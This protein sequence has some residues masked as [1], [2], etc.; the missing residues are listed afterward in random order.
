MFIQVQLLKGYSEPLLYEIPSEWE[1]QNLVGRLVR[2]PIRTQIKS[3][4]VLEQFATKPAKDT[5]A[6]R[7]A[8]AIE[9]F[10]DDPRY[11]S[12]IDQLSIYYQVNPLHFIKRVRLFLA[13]KESTDEIVT[14]L[15]DPE[16]NSKTIQ[17]TDEQ[18]AVVNAIAPHIATPQYFPSVLHGVTGSGKT[19]I[20]KQLIKDAFA[21]RKN[22][23]LLLPEVTL[24]L[25]FEKLLRKELPSNIPI[26]SFHSATSIKDKRLLWQL[27]LQQTPCLVIGVHLPTLLPLP[28]LGLIVVDEEHEVGY[29]EKKHPKVNSKDAAIWRASL[30]KIPIIL[31]SATPSLSSLYNVKTKGWHFFQ[32]KKRF[33]GSFPTITTVFLTDKKP[34][35]TFWI[36][37]QLENAIH[38]RLIKKEQT[39]I[40]LNRRGFSFFVQCKACSFIFKCRN[41]SVSLTLHNDNTV[42]CHY[43]ALTMPLP[44]CCPTCKR[45]ESQF[46]KKGIGTQQ[47]VSLLAQLFPQARI[48]RADLDVTLKK[49][50]WQ[51]TLHD[52]EQGAIDILVGTQT[53]T[54]GFH[55]PN[56]T[57]VG[58]L[59][60]DLNL[61]FPLFNASET[62]LQQL[63]QV[64]GR[65]GRT[66]AYSD[67]IVQAM[68]DH[69][70]FAYLNELAYVNF[71]A[72][73]MS[74][75]QELGYPPYKRL[76]E[77]ELKHI[78]ESIVEREAS[79]LMNHLMRLQEQRNLDLQILG[80]AKPPVY[81]IKNT[82]IRKIYIK[83]ES[84]RAIAQIFSLID[85]SFFKSNIFFTPNPLG[86]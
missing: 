14:Q 69:P 10:P 45:N 57:L 4:L 31:G 18:Q 16:D 27:L 74:N 35:R 53:I 30:H 8:L 78:H 48:A 20:Y 81:K 65:A 47:V 7:Q 59:W 72:N 75:R 68:I 17:L 13:E 42:T 70:I 50:V 11:R 83:G 1:T 23:L 38:D 26:K 55:F 82:H 39:I 77:L 36:S 52:F 54:K 63:I 56:V 2:V 67:V 79:I 29:Q 24:A 76:V 60:A 41:C 62:T 22:S 37:K 73:E 64:A 21:A 9:S 58:I 28:N 61:H 44:S 19:E 6:V 34:R 86:A 43:C 5:F 32:L 33:A 51:Q 84:I 85:R 49:K 80:P 40:F 46:L 12:F 15:L 3:A 66:H 25:Q 71:Y